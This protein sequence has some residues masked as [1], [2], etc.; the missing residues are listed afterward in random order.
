MK[1]GSTHSADKIKKKVQS[2]EWETMND[3]EPGKTIELK[4]HTGKRTMVH[5]AEENVD[6]NYIT[7]TY[8]GR[9]AARLKSSIS[10][11]G[12]KKPVAKDY[13]VHLHMSDGTKQVHNVNA[14]SRGHA[15]DKAQAK[16]DMSKA[17]INRYKIHESEE[18]GGEEINEISGKSLSKY[19]SK[20]V[21]DVL[22]SN[23]TARKEKRRKGADLAF[24]KLQGDEQKK[25]LQPKVY[26]TEETIDESKNKPYVRPHYNTK[27]EHNAWKASN[28]HG[29]VQYFGLDF[30]NAAKRHA[31][32]TD[33]MGVKMESKI[34]EKIDLKKADMGDVIDDFQ[35]SDAPQF[36]GKSKEKRRQMAIAAKMAAYES[37]EDDGW[38]STILKQKRGI[39]RLV[40]M[41][42]SMRP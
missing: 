30:K 21:P 2:G 31:G 38:Y 20:A 4:H 11:I 5:V 42:K 25:R 33:E 3:I 12:K 23:D 34:D 41:C 22:G 10:N 29:K 6:E 24:R 8:G 28:K 9:R 39:Q 18:L 14:L 13:S 32:L 37:V 1:Y 16:A 7:N 19:Y 40:K 35:N 36:K 27:G 17:G 15:L 26:A